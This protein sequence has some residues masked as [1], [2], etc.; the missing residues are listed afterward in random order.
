MP[1]ETTIKVRFSDLDPYD[2]VNHARYLSFFEAA[3]IEALDEMGFGMG[4]MKEQGMQIVLIE[5]HARYHRP[6]GLHDELTITTTVGEPTRATTLWHQE[7]RLSDG[8]LV[9]S[10]D[11]RAAF[12]DLLGRPRRA[13]DGFTVAAARF[14]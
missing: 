9:A 3:R 6:A 4:L 2:H 12:T 11:V 1:H 14:G 10:L 13:P 7:A 8:A 5:T